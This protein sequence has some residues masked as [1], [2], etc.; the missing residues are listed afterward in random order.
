MDIKYIK[1]KIYH[2]DENKKIQLGEYIPSEVIEILKQGNSIDREACFVLPGKYK[3]PY[4]YKSEITCS[5]CEKLL[6]KELTKTKLLNYLNGNKEILCD[7]CQAIEDDK[8]LAEHNEDQIKEQNYF[9][10]IQENTKNY[11]KQYLKPDQQWDNDMSLNDKINLI[12]YNNVNY[13]EI[14]NYIKS[15]TYHDFLK[16]LY[17]TT[18]SAYK[19]YKTGYKCALCGSNKQLAT[20]HRS[21]ER[22]GQEHL[23]KVI[24]EYLI[25][26]CN[27]C[28]N[29]FHDK[30]Q[31]PS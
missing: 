15:M 22:H 17:W 6:V 30:I 4:L 27:D 18:V 25:V 14:T 28:H 12:I 29:K 5:N 16:T 2:L 11:I 20:H 9:K 3:E 10:N 13:N 19:K 1:E 24:N 21:Y 7:E 8:K 26:L 31:V 23:Q